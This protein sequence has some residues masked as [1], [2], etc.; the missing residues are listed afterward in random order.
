MDPIGGE[1]IDEGVARKYVMEMDFF[2]YNF[3][4]YLWL[5]LPLFSEKVYMETRRG[6]GHFS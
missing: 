2:F 6:V 1:T 4:I 5:R 3:Y